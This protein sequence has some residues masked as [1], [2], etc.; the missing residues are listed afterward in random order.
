MKQLMLY[1]RN[2]YIVN[3]NDGEFIM[4]IRY[5]DF[6]HEACT[7]ETTNFKV[8]KLDFGKCKWIQ[9]KTLG[10]A[11]IFLGD[12]STIS[13][14]APAYS[15][16]QPNCIYFNFDREKTQ[17]YSIKAHDFGVY[18]IKDQ[19]F[20]QPCA[21]DAMTLLRMA[22]RPPIWVLPTFQL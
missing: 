15:G 10:D 9:K 7:R 16:C 1:R 6:D 19:S 2:A 12:N 4:V 18:N 20:S 5:F 17:N 8:F 3:L 21:T 13:V 22:D 11:A 14:L